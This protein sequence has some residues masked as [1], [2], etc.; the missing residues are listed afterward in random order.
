MNRPSDAE[1]VTGEAEAEEEATGEVEAA[2]EAEV[3]RNPSP[4]GLRFYDC[5]WVVNVKYEINLRD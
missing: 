5:I 3:D 4:S 2:T 1:E